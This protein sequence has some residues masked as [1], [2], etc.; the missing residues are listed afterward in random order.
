M[1]EG[2][3]FSLALMTGILGSG[4][5]IGMCGA[6]V[7]GFFMSTGKHTRNYLPYL[8][9]HGMRIFVYTVVGIIAATLGVVLVSTGLV[10]KIQGFLQIVVGALV[11][12]LALDILGVWPWRIAFGLLPTRVLSRG[13]AKAAA[14]G[15]MGGAALGGLVNGL[16][17]CS[18]TLAMAVK[19]TTAETFFEGGLLMFTF[20][21]G[22]L[23]SM[24]FVSMAFGKLGTGVRGLMLKIA[25]LIVFIMGVGTLYQGIAY[26]SVMKNLANW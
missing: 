26:F 10:G 1:T 25:A 15:T 17:P 12:I 19:A 5:C 4:H 13:F 23:P 16:M 18:L 20:G 24:V 21:L 8:A 7:S 11:I 2:L 14:S 9:Y 3:D 22:T 6:L